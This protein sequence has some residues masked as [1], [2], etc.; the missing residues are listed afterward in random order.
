M[1]SMDCRPPYMMFARLPMDDNSTI[2]STDLID[3]SGKPDR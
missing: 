3:F 1:Q 2:V